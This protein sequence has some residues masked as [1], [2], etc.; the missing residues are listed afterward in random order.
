M[1]KD[2]A[3]DL[4]K[5]HLGVEEEVILLDFKKT[6]GCHI[7]YNQLQAV[8]VQNKDAALKAEK[9]KKWKNKEAGGEID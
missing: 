6:K 7:K 2:E 3:M 4:L 5:R 9:E 8:Y 1:R